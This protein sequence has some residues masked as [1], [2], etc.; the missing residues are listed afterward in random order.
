MKKIVT[1]CLM[2]CFIGVMFGLCSCGIKKPQT[3]TPIQKLLEY[4]KFLADNGYVKDTEFE[5][6][7]TEIIA[8]RA[9][10]DM[11]EFNLEAE[12]LRIKAR[13][14]S[15]K[16]EMEKK[17]EAEAESFLRIAFGFALDGSSRCLEFLENYEKFCLDNKIELNKELIEKI[18]ETYEKNKKLVVEKISE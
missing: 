9:K 18:N 12:M 15:D 7:K 1:I 2:M 11:N 10:Y 6:A 5:I 14:I 4:A 13:V 17:P 8:K 3:P 16:K